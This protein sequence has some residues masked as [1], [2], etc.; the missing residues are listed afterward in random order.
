[1]LATLDRAEILAFQVLVESMVYEVALVYKAVVVPLEPLDRQEIKD[2]VAVKEVK[3]GG[4]TQDLLEQL[5]PLAVPVCTL[6][7]SFSLMNIY[8]MILRN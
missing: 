7:E 4:E 8:V 3:A 6:Y 2:E 5:E 1:L